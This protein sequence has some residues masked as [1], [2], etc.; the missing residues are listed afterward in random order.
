[1]T[2]NFLYDRFK[3]MDYLVGDKSS[4]SRYDENTP[5]IIKFINAD[6]A[7]A[8]LDKHI[9]SDTP[10]YLHADVDFDGIG[11]AYEVDNFIKTI[12]PHRKIK[13][14]INKEKSHG[15]TAKAVNFFNQTSGGLVIIVDSSSNEVE[16][17]RKIKHDVLIIDHHDITVDTK[18]LTG[19]TAGGKYTTVTNVLDSESF[20]ASSYFSAGLV[21]YE[22]L[23]YYQKTRGIT[24]ILED[25]RLY[26][27]A[28]CTLFTDVINT[29]SPRNLYYINRA[30][31]DDT[32]EVNLKQLIRLANKYKTNLS[33][34]LI[35]Y[36][37]A[38]MFNRAIRAGHSGDALRIALNSPESV[39]ELS[40][41]K[42]YQAELLEDLLVYAEE[43]FGYAKVDIGKLNIPASYTG[44][45]ASKLLDRYKKSS[46]AYLVE[47]NIVKGSFRGLYEDLNYRKMIAELGYFAEGHG[48]AFG[49]KIP[50]N[51]LHNVMQ[52]I[53]SL[54]QHY[55]KKEYLTCGSVEERGI[56]HIDDMNEFKRSGGLWKI[57][58]INSKICG[59]TGNL[60][61]I[62]S[63]KDV[64]L[65]NETDKMWEYSCCGIKCKAFEKIESNEVTLY[66][67][68][69]DSLS[70][71]LRNKWS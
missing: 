58:I 61:L 37:L 65:L 12:S 57:G 13:S 48:N 52:E 49:F 6:E 66:I 44:I 22:L 40:Q 35:G 43:S 34:S 68:Y 46:I 8:L 24:D 64:F 17:T 26:Q 50:V 31:S 32:L 14:C 55:S 63:I 70:F 53:T 15:I 67:E 19:N 5:E 51:E 18:M 56:H 62:A 59:G 7:C 60:N 47:D 41:F 2:D 29:D 30:F 54:E 69:D 28:V 9:K 27:W 38:P 10:I 45:A 21:V 33:K 4:C 71:Y 3:N 20:K 42:Q 23:R 36:S 39:L 1:M 11:S 25:K 16:L